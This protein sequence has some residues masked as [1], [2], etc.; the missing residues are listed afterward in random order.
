MSM[1]RRP[2]GLLQVTVGLLLLILLSTVC[3][4]AGEPLPPPIAAMQDKGFE[5]ISQF[6]APGK[7]VGYAGLLDGQPIALY[8][9]A[10][11]HYA[12]VGFAINAAGDYEDSDTLE[13]IITS[14]LTMR[15][16]L[17]RL[18]G[19]A[20][21]LAQLGDKPLLVNI[22]AAWCPPCRRELPMLTAA[23]AHYPG[24]TFAFVDLG[25]KPTVVR[26]FLDQQSL[27]LDN[28]LIDGDGELAELI[29][30]NQIPITL[31]YDT[32]G[33]LVD[34]HIGALTAADLAGI[35]QRLGIAID[36]GENSGRAGAADGE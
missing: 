5:L 23:Q 11:K 32:G 14:T 1:H 34:T 9:T 21:T 15:T 8:V 36:Q 2:F 33:R 31:F 7:L 13:A 18:D 20:V 27:Q 4:A 17:A 16:P 26:A 30:S 10:D 25:E 19:S 6:D 35:V 29:G 12:I 3:N 28:V 24:M 22:W